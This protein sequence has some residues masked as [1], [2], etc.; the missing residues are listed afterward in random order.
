MRLRV[1]VE[2]QTE[3]GFIK[4]TVAPHLV[5]FGVYATPIIVAS[6]DRD[7]RGSA[8]IPKGGGHWKWWYKDLHRLLTAHSGNEDR[9]TTLFDLYGLP[10]DFPG[11]KETGEEL[12]TKKRVAMLEDAMSEALGRNWRFIP[13]IQRHEFESMVLACLDSLET[14]LDDEQVP[15]LNALRA[16][17]GETP[18]E[19]VNDG[20]ETAPSKRLLKHIPGYGKVVHGLLALEDRGLSALRASCGRFDGWLTRLEHL[21][22]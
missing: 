13:Y 20:K 14:L 9:V 4:H 8:P 11:Y 2:G 5:A 3:L 16:E 19:D 21:K 6:A 10:P 7:R 1:V 12:D 17:L 22:E 15:G 18:P